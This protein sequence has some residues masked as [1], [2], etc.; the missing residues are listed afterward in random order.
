ML[1][2]TRD[3]LEELF[4]DPLKVWRAWATDVRGHGIESGHHMAEE[5]PDDLADA[6]LRH[7]V[8]V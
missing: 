1:W 5:A 8:A 7:F 4:G 3:D 6:L 2:S